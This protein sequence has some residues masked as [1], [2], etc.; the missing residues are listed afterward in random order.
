[1][2]SGLPANPTRISH[3][4]ILIIAFKRVEMAVLAATILLAAWTDYS[5]HI[6]RLATPIELLEA[7]YVLYFHLVKQLSSPVEAMISFCVSGI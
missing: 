4:F 2:F 1:M 5:D 7:G 6:C 3:G